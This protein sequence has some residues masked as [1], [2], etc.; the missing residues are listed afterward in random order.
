MFIISCLNRNS[1]TEPLGNMCGYHCFA[2][3]RSSKCQPAST[4]CGM[5]EP[6]VQSGYST[7]H[8]VQQRFLVDGK[9][10]KSVKTIRGQTDDL[11]TLQ[12][13]DWQ[14]YLI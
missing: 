11:V 9:E 10:A 13:L 5:E 7:V 2:L 12:G 6:P 3:N 1:V 14:S 4:M 8:T